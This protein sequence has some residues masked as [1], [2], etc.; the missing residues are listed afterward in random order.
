MWAIARWVLAL[1]SIGI[2]V[3]LVHK[4]PP[5]QVTLGPWLG[6]VVAL[7]LVGT[8]FYPLKT[9]LESSRWLPAFGLRSLPWQMEV[10][11]GVLFLGGLV[12]Y[13]TRVWSNRRS[14]GFF[15]LRIPTVAAAVILL[16]IA[17]GLTMW[18]Q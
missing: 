17:C 1:T 15:T 8:T 9:A 7:C 13:L 3:W 11:L 6:R 10:L 16:I 5:Q 12:V 14:E 4:K 2:A 18:P